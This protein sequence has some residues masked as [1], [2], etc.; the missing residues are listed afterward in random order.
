M[1]Y[2]YVKNIYSEKVDN[3]AIR[4]DVLLKEL[5]ITIVRVVIVRNPRIIK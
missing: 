3:I 4:G 1:K 2:M 5:M